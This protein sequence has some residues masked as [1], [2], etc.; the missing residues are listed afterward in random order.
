MRIKKFIQDLFGITQLIEEKRKQTEL[1]EKI[2]DHC[3]LQSIIC[4]ISLPRR[5]HMG[6]HN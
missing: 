6:N 2:A 1:L 4:D 5:L 3:T